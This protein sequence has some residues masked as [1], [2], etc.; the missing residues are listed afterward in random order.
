MKKNK[1]TIYIITVKSNHPDLSSPKIKD[2]SGNEL[3]PYPELKSMKGEYEVVMDR[4]RKNYP[5]VY[6]FVN[7]KGFYI[8]EKFIKTIRIKNV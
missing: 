2:K 8:H 3:E 7:H 6:V 4:D 5:D 1:Q